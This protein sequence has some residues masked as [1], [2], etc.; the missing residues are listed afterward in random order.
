MAV[1]PSYAPFS[2]SCLS[3]CLVGSEEESKRAAREAW[4]Q[5]C[6]ALFP[7]QSIASSKST[8]AWLPAAPGVAGG[9]PHT[10]PLG[11]RARATP[12]SPQEQDCPHSPHQR[13]SPTALHCGAIARRSHFRPTSLISGGP[14][15]HLKPHPLR[16]EP[17][18]PGQAPSQHPSWKA[19]VAPDFLRPLRPGTRKPRCL[20]GSVARLYGR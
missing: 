3:R 6:P 14:W 15:L 8:W 16:N 12:I 20:R 9:C 1:Q 13:T 2:L 18:S 4:E 10:Y 5:L 19:A 11:S 7:L 17:I